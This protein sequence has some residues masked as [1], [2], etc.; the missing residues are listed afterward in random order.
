MKVKKAISYFSKLEAFNKIHVDVD[1][2]TKFND[3][4]HNFNH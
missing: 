4:Y 1:K 2:K 3:L